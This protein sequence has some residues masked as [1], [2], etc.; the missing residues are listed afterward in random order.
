MKKKIIIAA[1]LVLVAA[2]PVFAANVQN[3]DSNDWSS[4]MFNRHQQMVQRNVDNGTITTEEA[5]QLNEHMRQDA[6]IMR[7]MM[8]KNGMRGNGMMGRGMMNKGQNGMPGN[9][10][11]NNA[12]TK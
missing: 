2:V 12:E 6:P 9:C 3:T 5:A 1:I 8:E 10:P 7:K 4:Q 11:F